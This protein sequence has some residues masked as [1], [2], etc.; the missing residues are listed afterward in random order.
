[1]TSEEIRTAE[2]AARLLQ[3][4]AQLF[5]YIYSMLRN[6]D[7]AEDLFQQTCLVLW[8]RYDQFDPARSFVAWACG[9]TRLEVL[10]FL[11]TRGRHPLYFTDDTNLLLIEAHGEIEHEGL[12]A[13]RRALD[14][15]RKKLR[16]RDQELLETCYGG[17]T[18]I[19]EIAQRWG[20]ST[21]SIHNSLRRIR[22]ALFECVRRVLAQ[23]GGIA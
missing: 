20:R 12:E 17:S 6:F 21:Q 14:E 15:C 10:Q 19:P 7:D 16:R 5:G 9:V 22:L 3:H 1:M 18:R 4:Q 11:R 8:D 23:E 2:F 13:R